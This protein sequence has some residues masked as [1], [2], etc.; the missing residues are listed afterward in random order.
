VL[1]FSTKYLVG[2][3]YLLTHPTTLTLTAY[4]LISQ[5]TAARHL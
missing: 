1:H 4:F 3:C 2:M 5:Q